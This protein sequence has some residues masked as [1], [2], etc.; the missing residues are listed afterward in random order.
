MKS[1]LSVSIILL[2]SSSCTP[3]N[4][5]DKIIAETD[6][7]RKSLYLIYVDELH[8][9]ST[10]RKS[11]DSFEA[12]ELSNPIS[13]MLKPSS[14]AQPLYPCLIRYYSDR[15][16]INGVTKR[17]VLSF[18]EMP[19]QLVL[20]KEEDI[21]SKNL[22]E[23]VDVKLVLTHNYIDTL[24]YVRTDSLPTEKLRK[25]NADKLSQIEIEAKKMHMELCGTAASRILAANS[26]KPH[27]LLDSAQTLFFI[28]KFSERKP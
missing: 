19:H 27:A 26:P 24:F 3:S 21:Y 14:K 28:Q 25:I 1:F 6:S 23:F 17:K 22:N 5:L 9:D 13:E 7:S 16:P 15:L 4:S 10:V 20:V 8:L 12:W 18:K 11:K 2:I